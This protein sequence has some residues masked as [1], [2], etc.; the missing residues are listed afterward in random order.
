MKKNNLLFITILVIA[1]GVFNSCDKDD[2]EINYDP[3]LIGTWMREEIFE[4]ITN[5]EVFTFNEDLT[6]LYNNFE[7]GDIADLPRPISYKVEND[8]IT[9]TIEGWDQTVTGTY[10]FSLHTGAEFE[11]LHLTIN[12]KTN[13]FSK[14]H[15][16]ENSYGN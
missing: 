15:F 3:E 14:M 7:K 11:R 10:S 9:M 1:L 5:V 13:A 6:G 12:G 8:I 16:S 2:D 4:E